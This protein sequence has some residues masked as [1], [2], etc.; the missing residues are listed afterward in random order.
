MYPEL[1][2]E[3]KRTSKKVAEILQNAGLEIKT[4]RAETG[5]LAILKGDQKGPTVL[6]RADMDAL[7][8]SD[9][10]EVKYRS[11]IPG[12]MHACGHDAHTAILV[13]AARILNQMRDSIRGQVKFVF[14]PAE[15]G[16]GGAARMIEEGIL[17]DPEVDAAFALHTEPHC[18]PGEL[19]YGTG[20]VTANADEIDLILQGK[21]GHGARPQKGVDALTVAGQVI[22]S[23]QQLMSRMIDPCERA[24]LTFGK[25]NGGSRRNVIADLIKMEGTL[26]TQSDELREEIP[27]LIRQVVEGVTSAFGA[28]F[29][30]E[31]NRGYPGVINDEK[32]A[33][34]L[35]M[36]ADNLG[37]IKTIK[38]KTPSM[39]GEDFAYF[40]RQVPSLLFRL[41]TGSTPK[42]R[43]P[44]HHP[45]FDID[46]KSLRIGMEIMTG[47]V[48]NFLEEKEWKK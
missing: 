17:K 23:L 1:G 24:V 37:Q 48:I 16:P 9:Q 4:G 12:V 20:P 28:S 25:I 30:M 35:R 18:M 27:V 33:E 43:F 32:L 45:S 39:G 5:V 42:N 8:L 31:L 21:G 29:S 36:T 19:T 26:R 44:G 22:V 11:Q 3:E 14:Q 2:M 40:S 34:L 15:E 38:E 13:G 47:L 6:L 46:E 41:G 7:P 10:K